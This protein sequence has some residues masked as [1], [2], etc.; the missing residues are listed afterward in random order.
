MTRRVHATLGSDAI[1][2]CSFTF[3]AKLSTGTVH[4]Y[5]K[6][7]TTTYVFHGNASKVLEMYRGKTKLIGNKD[8]GNCGLLIQNI[9]QE[10]QGIYLRIVVNGTA[11]SFLND[12]V[13]ITLSGEDRSQVSVSATRDF[14]PDLIKVEPQYFL[15]VYLRNTSNAATLVLH[16]T[17]FTEASD[18]WTATIVC[19]ATLVPAALVAT[20]LAGGIFWRLKC[21]R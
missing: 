20:L 13:N 15:H 21:K 6:K 10:D 7:N 11:Y 3:P 2:R 1:V 19:V 16:F 5:W 8:R 4:V 14:S 12:R 9:S 17:P 18:E